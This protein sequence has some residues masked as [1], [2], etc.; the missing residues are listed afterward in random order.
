MFTIW[1]TIPIASQAL[2]TMCDIFFSISNYQ[3]DIDPKCAFISAF[4]HVF[5]SVGNNNHERAIFCK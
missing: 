2:H 3:N 1:Q 4:I 5:T